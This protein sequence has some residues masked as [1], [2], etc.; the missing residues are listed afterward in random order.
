MR[1]FSFVGKKFCKESILSKLLWLAPR[2]TI[3]KQMKRTFNHWLVQFRF[4]IITWAEFCLNERSNYLDRMGIN[5]ANDGN[6][7]WERDLPMFEIIFARTPFGIFFVRLQRL[8]LKFLFS[9]HFSFLS[10]PQTH[11]SWMLYVQ[12]TRIVTNSCRFPSRRKFFS[13]STNLYRRKLTSIIKSSC[14]IYKKS[15]NERM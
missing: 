5:F 10:M 6:V 11:P 2:V 3:R 12:Y 14:E 15:K 8:S 1:T 13:H 7:V 9:S 4:T